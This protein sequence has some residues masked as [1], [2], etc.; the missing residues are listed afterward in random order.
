VDS[1][2]KTTVPIAFTGRK[3]SIL[4]LDP[5][6]LKAVVSLK[7]FTPSPKDVVIHPIVKVQPAVSGVVSTTP[8]ITVHLIPVISHEGKKK[9]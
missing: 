3:E 1:S 2:V 8:N 9:K 7:E 5:E 4:G 6:E